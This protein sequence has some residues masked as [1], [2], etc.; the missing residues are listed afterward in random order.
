MQALVDGQ[1]VQQPHWGSASGAI[2]GFKQILLSFA[3]SET[4]K[5]DFTAHDHFKHHGFMS[6]AASTVSKTLLRILYLPPVL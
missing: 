5:G 2:T 3:C 6:I 1:D 4:L